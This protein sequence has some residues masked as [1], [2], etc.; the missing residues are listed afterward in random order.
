MLVRS[1]A[2]SYQYLASKILKMILRTFGSLKGLGIL[3]AV[4]TDLIEARLLRLPPT[5]WRANDLCAN[6]DCIS[7]TVVL[8]LGTI[9]R[10]LDTGRQYSIHI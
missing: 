6:M 3:K 10:K 2:G 1:E 4:E 9:L 5:R 8:L 7:V